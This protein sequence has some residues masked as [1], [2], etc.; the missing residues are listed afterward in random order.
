M[1]GKGL[2]HNESFE[3]HFLKL[4]YPMVFGIKFKARMFI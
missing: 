4:K 3:T 2:E 1:D